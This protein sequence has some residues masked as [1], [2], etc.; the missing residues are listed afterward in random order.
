ME[1]EASLVFLWVMEGSTHSSW[2]VFGL[3]GTSANFDPSANLIT[4][5][6]IPPA[7]GTWKHSVGV[8]SSILPAEPGMV[9][10]NH[11]FILDF[12]ILVFWL[13]CAGCSLLCAG[14]L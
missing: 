11:E 14:F 13:C 9:F 7:P 10:F 2:A 5:T 1:S 6:P 4:P 8:P 12:E 3:S